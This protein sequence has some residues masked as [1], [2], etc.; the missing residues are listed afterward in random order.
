MYSTLA[1]D[2]IQFQ[3]HHARLA[4]ANGMST[5]SVLCPAWGCQHNQC[6]YC[7]V[8]TVEKYD[9]YGSQQEPLPVVRRRRATTATEND[10]TRGRGGGGMRGNQMDG[11]WSGVE[12]K[13]QAFGAKDTPAVSTLEP[14]SQQESKVWGLPIIKDEEREPLLNEHA[15]RPLET[16]A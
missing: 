5:K 15:E 3:R 7:S 9:G 6:D 8:E 13:G 2:T 12:Q 11:P 10:I 16:L 1:R 4:Q 14:L